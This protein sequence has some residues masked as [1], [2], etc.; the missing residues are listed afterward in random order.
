VSAF[1]GDVLRFAERAKAIND[2]TVR[3][4]ALEV[5]NSLTTGSAVTGSQ[6][7]PV[8]TGFAI[9]SWGVLGSVN[10]KG[11][12][13]E[14]MKMRVGDSRTIEG[15]AVYLARLEDGHARRKPAGWVALTV[16]M[17]PRVVAW[18][19]QQASGGATRSAAVP[20]GAT[21]RRA[22]AITGTPRTS[23]IVTGRKPAAMRSR[24]RRKFP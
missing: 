15:R 20:G 5:Y 8:D 1:T 18:A 4:A 2:Q 11:A 13:A 12:A 21:L 23:D 3:I 7:T 14:L 10:G 22:A 17:W 6:G 16:R 24:S 19:V 9:N